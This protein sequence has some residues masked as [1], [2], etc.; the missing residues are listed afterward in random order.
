[1]VVAALVLLG[2][3]L[4]AGGAGGRSPKRARRLAELISYPQGM[5][6]EATAALPLRDPR[7]NRP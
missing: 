4:V 6:Y 3:A 2:F 1:M 5:A 7:D